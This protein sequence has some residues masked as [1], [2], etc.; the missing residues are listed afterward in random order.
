MERDVSTADSSSFG[1]EQA[2]LTSRIIGAQKDSK[3]ERQQRGRG[4]GLEA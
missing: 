3:W 1:R 4:W 2:K